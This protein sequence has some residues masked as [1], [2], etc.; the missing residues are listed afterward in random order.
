MKTYRMR[1]RESFDIMK[2]ILGTEVLRWDCDRILLDGVDSVRVWKN[3][4]ES[5]ERKG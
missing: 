5:T 1:L 2:K 4:E 3:A